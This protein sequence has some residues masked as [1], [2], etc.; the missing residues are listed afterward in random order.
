MIF[1]SKK[2]RQPVLRRATGHG[3]EHA[4]EKIPDVGTSP[5][6]GD[7]VRIDVVSTTQLRDGVIDARQC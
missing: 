1:E 7:V 3:D 2:A 6:Q 4:T 5:L